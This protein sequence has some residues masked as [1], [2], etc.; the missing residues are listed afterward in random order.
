ML[1]KSRRSDVDRPEVIPRIVISTFSSCCPLRCEN[2]TTQRF[3]LVSLLK[4]I[5]FEKSNVRTLRPLSMLV[6]TADGPLYADGCLRARKAFDQS[7]AGDPLMAAFIRCLFGQPF[8]F[9]FFSLCWSGRA[10]RAICIPLSLI[11]SSLRRRMAT[12]RPTPACQSSF[13]DL[14]ARCSCCCSCRS[15]C[16]SHCCR[17]FGLLFV[18]PALT[19]IRPTTRD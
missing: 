13:R 4:F 16:G 19:V 9:H 1:D 7:D 6:L 12:R 2:N 10:Y 15:C 17:C 5:R 11:R 3:F 14:R 8:V 18:S